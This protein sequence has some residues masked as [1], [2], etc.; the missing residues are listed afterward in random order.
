[1]KSLFFY[2]MLLSMTLASCGGNSK[3]EQQNN[4]E[5]KEATSKLSANHI[6]VLYFHGSQRCITC[7]A[8]ES[9]TLALLDSL[10]TKEKADGKIVFRVIDISDEK[11]EKIADKYE[12]TW[13]SLF[14]NGWKNG[15]ES[16]NNM[17][18]FGFSYAKNSPDEFKKGL[19]DKIDQ[20]LSEL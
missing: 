6:E 3:S 14:V 9:N 15:K 8:I 7:R 11:N 17:T 1:M 18:E 5:P 2:L 12:V 13:S 16:V 4:N 10:Y 19:K 20:M